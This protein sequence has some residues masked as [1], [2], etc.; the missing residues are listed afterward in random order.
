MNLRKNYDLG[1]LLLSEHSEQYHFEGGIDK[2]VFRVANWDSRMA[3]KR[4]GDLLSNPKLE[5]EGSEST[6]QHEGP[7]KW[8]DSKSWM[9]NPGIYHSLPNSV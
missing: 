2:M 7:K 8:S 9:L 1:L 3:V 4:A 6:N 5:D